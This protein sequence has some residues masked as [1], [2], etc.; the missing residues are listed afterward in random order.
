MAKLRSTSICY[1]MPIGSI[2]DDLEVIDYADTEKYQVRKLL[3]KCRICGRTKLKTP[4]ELNR[5]AGTTHK[6]CGK[7]MK[8]L[9]KDFHSIWQGLKQRIYNPNGE[10]W[11]RYGGRGLTCDYDAFADFYDDMYE[12]FVEARKTIDRP[13][14]DRI[15]NDLGYVRG[16]LRW[17]DRK[18][19]INNSSRMKWFKAI[20]PEGELFVAMNQSDFAIEHGLKSR[21][22]SACL[23]GKIRT[24]LGWRFGYIDP[25]SVTTSKP[26]SADKA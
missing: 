14:I 19:N 10:H 3:C 4:Y 23:C 6:A 8:M 25:E 9:D 26:L 17:V 21:Q 1:K 7:G 13:E 15:N 16:N 18:T 22:I 20:S 12:S 5:H 2:V 11:D 24:T